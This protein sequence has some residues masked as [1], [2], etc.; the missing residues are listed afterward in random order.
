M[1]CVSQRSVLLFGYPTEAVDEDYVTAFICTATTSPMLWRRVIQRTH[2][3]TLTPPI[4]TRATPSASSTSMS[5]ALNEGECW[6]PVRINFI[7]DMFNRCYTS[8]SETRVVY[9]HGISRQRVRPSK[10]RIRECDEALVL[11]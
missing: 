1:F 5:A 7:F 3:L 9:L 4:P 6:T 8:K 2:T 10:L 11:L